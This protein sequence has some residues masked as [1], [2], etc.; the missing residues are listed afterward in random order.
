[1]KYGVILFLAFSVVSASAQQLQAGIKALFLGYDDNVGA[2]YADIM[3]STD[4]RFDYANSGYISDTSG[5]LLPTLATLQQYDSVLVWSN[6]PPEPGLADRLADYVD[7]G[8]GV[9]L[10]TFT[11]FHASCCDFS[12]RI[13]TSG[14]NPLTTPTVQAYNTRTLGAFDSS[15]PLMAAVNSL[16]SSD[17]NG[18]WLDVDSGATVAASWDDGSPLAAINANGNVANITLFPNVAE[19]GHALGDYRQLFRNALA[20]TGSSS[21]SAVPEPAS[22]AIWAVGGLGMLVSRRNLRSIKARRI[23][24]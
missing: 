20:E 23:S 11:G 13:N 7:A 8:G 10:A 21:I 5:S 15:N 19:F 22:I 4:S 12:G 14:Y 16:S 24:I 2:T 6:Y 9:V 18:D 3:G 17:F 1:M